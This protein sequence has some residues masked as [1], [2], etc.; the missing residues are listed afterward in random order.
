[1]SFLT[2]KKSA[3]D[4]IG[5]GRSCQFLTR[6][7][8]RDRATPL[9]AATDS[10]RGPVHPALSIFGVRKGSVSPRNVS[11]DGGQPNRSHEQQGGLAMPLQK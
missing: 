6:K 5:I 2:R 4:G 9:G 3:W 11:A 8:W 7:K 10:S 1:M